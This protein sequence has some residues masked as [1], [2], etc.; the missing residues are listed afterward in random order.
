M[1]PISEFARAGNVTIRALRFYDEL[2]L[3]SPAYVVPES[4]YRRYSPTQF[5][6]LNQI[7]AFKDMGFSLQEI[8]ELLQR[9]LDAQELGSLLEARREVLRKR[10][11][12]DAGRLERIEARL[13]S[14]SAGGPQSHLTIMLRTTPGQSVVSLRE[15]LQNYDQV[16]ELFTTLERRVDPRVLYDQRGAI[17][18]RCLEGDGEIDCEAVRFLKQPVVA[19][20][21]FKVYESQ[22]A[23]VAFTYH[24]GSEDSICTTYQSMT[25]WIAAQGYQLSAAK[26]EIYWPAPENKGATSSLTEIQFPVARLRAVAR[27]EQQKAS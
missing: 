5:A 3:L 25:G 2:G 19:I 9:R 16:D 7:Q 11:R 8:R 15:K 23:R 14:I 13:N 10:V 12:D 20:R 17:F 6:Q 24:Y 27:S 26:R 4:G 1:L 21:G 22:R 18:H